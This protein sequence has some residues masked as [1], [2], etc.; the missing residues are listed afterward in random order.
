MLIEAL[1]K[2][3]HPFDFVLLPGSAHGPRSPEQ[4]WTVLQARWNF[5]SKNL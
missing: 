5:I 1:Q 3:G 4:M 2:A